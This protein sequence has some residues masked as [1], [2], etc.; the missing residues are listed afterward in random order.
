MAKSNRTK[1]SKKPT[2]KDKHTLSPIETDLLAYCEDREP[3][4]LY[5]KDDYVRED[6][7]KKIHSLNDGIDIDRVYEGRRSTKRIDGMREVLRRLGKDPLVDLKRKKLYKGR[8]KDIIT[9][10]RIYKF[11]DNSKYKYTDKGYE[12]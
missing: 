10:E 3:V 6:L 9:N 8:K 4:L 2:T 5:G 1:S 11:K 7:I 12:N